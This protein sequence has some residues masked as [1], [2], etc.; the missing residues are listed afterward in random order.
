MLQPR[1]WW[2]VVDK[3]AAQQQQQQQQAD[4]DAPADIKSAEPAAAAAAAAGPS[5]AVQLVT[6]RVSKACCLTLCAGNA[7]HMRVGKHVTFV[8]A[9]HAVMLYSRGEQVPD[10]RRQAG[11]GCV[12]YF[13]WIHLMQLL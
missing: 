3:T 6:N 11:S 12:C 7:E 8:Q 5:Y 13:Y 1:C 2:E 9:Q 10:T 4:G